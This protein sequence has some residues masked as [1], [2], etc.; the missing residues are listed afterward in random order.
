[1][2]SQATSFGRAADAYARARPD[3]PRAAIDWL[4]DQAVR[5]VA[6]V[7]AGTG[8]LS[9]AIAATG[10]SVVAV[11]PD[12]AMLAQLRERH[13]AIPAHVGRAEALPLPDGSAD[14]VTFGQSWH[15]VQVDPASAEA[16]RVLRP[17]GVLGLLWNTRDAEVPWVSE[18]GEIV[19]ASAGERIILDEAVRVAAPFGTVERHTVAWQT[20][21]TV[22]RLVALAASR[23]AVI[24]LPDAQRAQVLRRVAALGD[25]VAAN[26][27]SIVL[28]YR[29]H[30][31]RARLPR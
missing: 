11:D 6:D 14:A 12:A 3:Y 18:F 25:R 16:A 7:G 30:V 10:R 22:D 20:S 29:T 8:K 28:P 1:M 9:A 24:E 27:G 2:S 17:G 19:R 31:F 4:L 23:S 21:I 13:P 15:W 5:E 26:D